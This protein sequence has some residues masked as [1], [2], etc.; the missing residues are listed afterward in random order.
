MLGFRFT[1]CVALAVLCAEAQ[2]SQNSLY[3]PNSLLNVGQL[4][5]FGGILPPARVHHTATY[6]EPYVLVYG[7]SSEHG[8]LLDDM[9]MYDIRMQKWT[10]AIT[11][12]ECCNRAEELVQRLGSTTNDLV[13][14]LPV[15][16]EGGLP[17][18][19]AEHAAATAQGKLFMFGGVTTFG[20]MNDMFT[21][22][23]V[24]LRWRSVTNAESSWPSRRAGH[25]L[26]ASE[27]HL[28]L[29]G[30]RGE[31]DLSDGV[32]VS[33]NDVWI[34]DVNRNAWS[35]SVDRQEATP[36]GRQHAATTIFRRS[37]WVFGGMQADTEVAFNDLWAFHLDT[38]RWK[39]FSPNA[40]D[41]SG[42][43]P[44]PL[45]HAHLLPTSS[46]IP[47]QRDGV[48][49]YGGIGSGGGC[50]GEAC[51]AAHT[52]VGQLYRFD[53][54]TEAWASVL[55]A[56][57][58]RI[59]Q[60]ATEQVVGGDW[61]YARIS[62]DDSR[63]TG[64]SS[65]LTKRVALERIAIAQERCLV[66]EFGGVEFD[67]D[68]SSVA[69]VL[70]DGDRYPRADNGGMDLFAGERS[71]QGNNYYEG[72]GILHNDPWDLYTA[73]HTRENLE[74]PIH[75]RWWYLNTPYA[76]EESA[77]LSFSRQF[78]QYSIAASDLV[79]LSTDRSNM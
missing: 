28:V 36:A 66:F 47:T 39:Q 41:L 12:E 33:L 25:S 26:E 74:V 37:L 38:H 3:P 46:Q 24:E 9:H 17:A 30:G 43:V 16:F 1:L 64:G 54:T 21:F 49:V 31:G 77:D 35:I 60:P 45:H 44:P 62:S 23:P 51:G 69:T 22:D 8:N 32:S 76:V 72:G 71:T 68:N 7:G 4:Y 58:S 15:G 13:S 20:L 34:F 5:N 42:F 6:V 11:R 67:V 18:G 79:L 14:E 75:P 19:R 78:R 56:G 53:I 70:P 52:V 63:G 27:S 10:G 55:E 2:Y 61:Q 57:A 48:M 29:F 59:T 40:G 73:E 65:K 50:G